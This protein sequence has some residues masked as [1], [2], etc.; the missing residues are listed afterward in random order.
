MYQLTKQEYDFIKTGM[1][2]ERTF[3]IRQHKGM[4]LETCQLFQDYIEKI[5]LFPQNYTELDKE[6]TYKALIKSSLFWKEWSKINLKKYATLK[7]QQDN[8]ALKEAFRN[9]QPCKKKA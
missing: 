5:Q 2:M 9:K 7:A 6:I 8:K 1:K 4:P 3:D